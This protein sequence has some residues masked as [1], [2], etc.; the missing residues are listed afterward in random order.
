MDRG[1]RDIDW[2]ADC[3]CR[4]EAVLENR[5]ENIRQTKFEEHQ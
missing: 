1:W 2:R 3:V 5:A 4:E